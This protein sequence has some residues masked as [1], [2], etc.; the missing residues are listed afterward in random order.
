M[1]GIPSRENQ[2]CLDTAANK[3]KVQISSSAWQNK[4]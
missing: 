4:E 3:G 2:N 1:P